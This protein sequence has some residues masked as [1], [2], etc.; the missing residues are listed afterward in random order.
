VSPTPTLAPLSVSPSNI[1]INIEN[2]TAKSGI[3]HNVATKLEAQG[4]HIGTV[5]DA[6]NENYTSTIVKYGSTKVQ[7]SQT[8]AESVPGSI[9]KADP[10]AGSVITLIIGSDFTKVV[11]VTISSGG[12][13]PSPTPTPSIS[14]ISA[15]KPG[16]LS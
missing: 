8:V 12:T 6:P 11:P 3:A 16:C 10:T 4:F 2:G 7:S 15:A 9:R 5:G 1:T 14:S 13:S